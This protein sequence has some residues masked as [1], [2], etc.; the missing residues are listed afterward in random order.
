[1]F[2]DS[3]SL[4][5]QPGGREPYIM[6]EYK[7]SNGEVRVQ[8]KFDTDVIREFK[9]YTPIEE[10]DE[11]VDLNGAKRCAS[12]RYKNGIMILLLLNLTLRYLL[13]Q[14]KQP[15]LSRISC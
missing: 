1:M 13:I 15:L 8:H 14:Q 11:N 6:L 9:Y 4:A 2:S 7:K 12:K 3:C 10:E 5:Y